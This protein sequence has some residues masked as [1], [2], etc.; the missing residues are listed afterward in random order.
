M[1]ADE[2]DSPPAPRRVRAVEH[3]M[4]VLDAINA[5]D[6]QAGVSE[7]ARQTGLSKAAVHH[8]LATLADRRFVTQDAVTSQYRLGWALYE[9]GSSVVHGLR[10][11]RASAPHLAWLAAHTGESVLLSILSEDELL[12]VASA[13]A[14]QTVRMVATS[15][16]RS[17]LH[18][19]ASGKI[20]LAFSDDQEMVDR[21]ISK[22]LPRWTPTTITQPNRIRTDLAKVKASGFATCWEEREVGLCSIAIPIRDFTGHVVAALALAGPAGR[23]NEETVG[24]HLPPLLQTG[25]RIQLELGVR[26]ATLRAKAK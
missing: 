3:A 14:P 4:D 20:L 17:A 5:L 19:T 9:L 12:Y 11:E 26:P 15:G 13:D 23:L 8:L 2:A 22:A 7:I 10:L 18:A 6:G 16:R 1:T 24:A 25:N 21:I